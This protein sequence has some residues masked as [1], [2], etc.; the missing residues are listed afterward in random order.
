MTFKLISSLEFTS[1][2]SSGLDSLLT[3]LWTLFPA[4]WWKVKGYS[5]GKGQSMKQ[6]KD[7]E[8]SLQST[9]LH[10][11]NLYLFVYFSTQSLIQIRTPSFVIKLC[12][13]CKIET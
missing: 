1:A 6:L 4:A 2:D 3:Y 5:N 9:A 12:V 11:Q 13:S 7:K 8:R 10:K